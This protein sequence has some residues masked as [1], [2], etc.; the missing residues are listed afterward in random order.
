MF[1]F[2]LSIIISII[3][4]ILFEKQ[5]FAFTE[6]GDTLVIEQSDVTKGSSLGAI[7]RAD[8]TEGGMRAH[9]VYE[10]VENAVYEL[11]ETL[12]YTGYYLEIV[13]PAVRS[14]SAARR[15]VILYSMDFKGWYALQ[16]GGLTL[17]HV[18]WEQIENVEGGRITAWARGGINITET[19]A[20][21]VLHDL[22][23]DF[24]TGFILQGEKND[25]KL[26][27][28]NCLFRFNK[29]LDNSVWTGQG[30]DLSRA[31]LDTVL[32]RDCTWYGGGAFLVS[33]WESTQNMFSM[34][35]CTI[36]DFV[37]FPINGKHWDNAYFT[38]NL[39]YNAHTMGE[40]SSLR[41][42]VE[43]DTLPYGIINIDTVHFVDLSTVDWEA[44]G[45]RLVHVKSNNNY[46]TPNIKSYW[47]KAM[48]DT[49]YY[50]FLVADPEFHDGFM[51]SRTRAMFEDEQTYPN[52]ALENTR[53]FDPLFSDY[54]DYSD[55]LINYSRA[56][57]NYAN[58]YADATTFMMDPDGDPLVPTDP[59]IYNLRVTNPLLKMSATDG[60]VIGDR[61]WELQNGYNN[62]SMTDPVTGIEDDVKNVESNIADFILKQNYP[63]PFNPI[64]TICYQLE[65][66]G[67]I[68]LSVYDI[69]GREIKR[70]VDK[71]QK[72]GTY[73]I[74]F[75]VDGIASGIY[76]FTLEAGTKTQSRKMIFLK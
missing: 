16:G 39:F 25:I 2:S 22:V 29:A 3:L 9:A 27:V 42:G 51:N 72:S 58:P 14:S 70:L 38:N 64:T 54:F 35:H 68:R 49:N 61:T 5:V 73:S 55:T 50:G 13:G 57:Y 20:E 45:D 31:D 65:S 6:K 34:D 12:Y 59:M 71:S 56:Y 52:L 48:D 1:K 19:N 11:E 62:P 67:H 4:I 15:P 40:D 28:T 32:F 24:N 75:S 37:Q 53:S 26:K 44:E 76:V 60:H 69:T 46:I 7:I 10:L 74:K 33:T 30:F 23:W 66:E 43:P 47:Y 18:H 21:I 41:I 8:T 36:V 63:N 17:K